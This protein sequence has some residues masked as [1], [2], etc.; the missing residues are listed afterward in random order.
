MD[1]YL[2]ETKL[3][4]L[5]SLLR[6]TVEIP[7]IVSM[8]VNTNRNPDVSEEDAV[9][10]KMVLASKYPI[11]G[12]TTNLADH[13]DLIFM[14]SKSIVE[15]EIE[16]SQKFF[17]DSKS[18]ELDYLNVPY[19]PFSEKAKVSSPSSIVIRRSFAGSNK[20]NFS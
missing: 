15:V 2:F 9:P 17:G 3:K 5:W 12:F 14:S 10:A 7:P 8:V 4:D 11:S 19:K 13:R 20:S 18:A 1:A 6:R 16:C